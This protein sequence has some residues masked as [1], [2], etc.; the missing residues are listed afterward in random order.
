MNLKQIKQISIIQVLSKYGVKPTKIQRNQA[1]FYAINR[2]E[3][4]PSLKV[5]IIKN[6]F[7]DFGTFTGGSVIDIIMLLEGCRVREAIGK[8]RKMNDSNTISFSQVE[9]KLSNHLSNS[10]RESAIQI[11][12]ISELNNAR[13]LTFLEK[14]KIPTKIARRF[15]VE[16]SYSVNRKNYYGIGFKND[17]GGFEIRNEYFKGSSSPKSYTTIKNDNDILLVFEGFFDFLSIFVGDN[18]M[19]NKF[20]F[21]ILNS[22]SFYKRIPPEIIENYTMVNLFLDNDLAGETITND[23]KSRFSNI[24]DCSNKYENY[25]DLNDFIIE[26]N[27]LNLD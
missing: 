3:R 13:L 26:N 8:L 12:K 21:L 15:C 23:F 27:K 16:L 25:K 18:E 19:E 2:K 9:Y 5:D 10:K 4:T 7:F 11:Q 14:R 6:T 17:K 22:L 20:D 1:W 24:V